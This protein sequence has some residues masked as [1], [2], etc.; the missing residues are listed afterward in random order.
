MKQTPSLI[1][2]VRN[3]AAL[4]HP[5]SLIAQIVGV[6][7]VTIWRWLRPPAQGPQ[8]KPGRH[9]KL[10]VRQELWCV[11]AVQVNPC[12]T[13]RDLQ[14]K[15]QAEFSMSLS[16]S[17]LHRL[18][19]KHDITRKKV[20]KHYCEQKQDKVDEFMAGLPDEATRTWLAVDECGF[21]MNMTPAYGY[22]P[23]GARVV[24]S[25]PGPRGK[26]YSLVLCIA[27]TGVVNWRL[28]PGGLKGPDF[29]AF[30]GSLPSHVSI[31]LDNASIH[32]AS[33]Q[34]RKVNLPTVSE[35]ASARRQHLA[36]LPAYSPQ[37]NPTE[38]A[39]NVVRGSVTRCQ[40][41]TYEQLHAA[42]MRAMSLLTPE[43]C[44]GFFLHCWSAGR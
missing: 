25:R 15:V 18:L 39:F 30:L 9:T 36:Y 13:L 14:V 21:V 6:S 1:T 44:T 37:L 20:S 17:T 7:R 38:L 11:Q 2:V 12:C 29:L 3:L 43:A 8:R 40:P 34:L 35:A 5:V 41:R 10:T 28:I 16:L 26:R 23:R 4:Q 31:C 33:K 32:H 22:G 42:V 27:P 19:L 24:V